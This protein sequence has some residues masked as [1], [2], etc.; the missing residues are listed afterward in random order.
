METP[1]GDPWQWLRDL[2]SRKAPW[3]EGF[4]WDGAEEWGDQRGGHQHDD[5]AA[6]EAGSAVPFST[7]HLLQAPGKAVTF[8]AAFSSPEEDVGQGTG[9]PGAQGGRGAGGEVTHRCSSGTAPRHR[10]HPCW[11]HPARG[12][13][14]P[15]AGAWPLH[16]QR[17]R[18]IDKVPAVP[19]S[20]PFP[21][22][23][24]PEGKHSWH[25][26]HVRLNTASF[27][28]RKKKSNKRKSGSATAP[29][30][31]LLH[32][33]FLIPALNNTLYGEA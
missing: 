10:R 31:A 3:E 26:C 6:P 13:R 23:P 1:T 28:K 8:S 17:G 29:F 7:A 15:A 21:A 24:S 27:M 4:L 20:G 11:W 22:L 18:C 25:I 2:C 12:A 9:L 33:S 19:F 5:G 16:K 32:S 14:G 30:S